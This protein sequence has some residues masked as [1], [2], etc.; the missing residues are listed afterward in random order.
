MNLIDDVSV[1]LCAPIHALGYASVVSQ[2]TSA[3][4]SVTGKALRR[5]HLRRRLCDPAGKYLPHS[6]AAGFPGMLVRRCG[7]RYRLGL[8]FLRSNVCGVVSRQTPHGTLHTLGSLASVDI[9]TQPLPVCHQLQT[10][11]MSHAPVVVV[12][13]RFAVRRNSKLSSIRPLQE[14]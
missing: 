12:H 4:S 5:S 2:Q 14:Q 10:I 9:N 8:C 3:P 13:H 7:P 1:R 6:P 11:R